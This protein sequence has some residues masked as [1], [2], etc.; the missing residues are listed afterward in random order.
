MSSWVSLEGVPL[1]C[2]LHLGDILDSLQAQHGEKASEASLARV[3]DAFAPLEVPVHHVLGNHFLANLP[4]AR[5]HAALGIPHNPC[6]GGAAAYSF[7]PAQGF[8]VV[9]LD[10]YDV[11]LLGWPAGD[12]RRTE[13]ELLLQSRN[14][15]ANPNSPEGLQGLE[16]RF[17]AFGGGASA[18]QLAWLAS[19]LCDADVARERV[20]IAL[21]TPVHPDSSP[22]VCL[23][24]NYEQLAALVTKHACVVAT[25]AGHAHG[26]GQC[27]D[28]A[29]CHHF[30]LP[31]VLECPPG[32][33]AFG[34]LEIFDHGFAIRGT[35][36]MGSTQM[37]PFRAWGTPEV[38]PVA[39]EQRAAQRIA[40]VT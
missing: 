12:P 39:N 10:S 26:G 1:S 19:L 18:Q 7:S 6:A 5:L 37:L 25:L 31:A 14:P 9:V 11:S 38:Q 36:R 29:G 3:L 2:V 35:G 20:F 32:E 21:H 24:W 28:A 16:R 34:H 13:A 27:L 33:N 8:R 30:V 22:P 40:N 23:L 17:V 4:R 15:N